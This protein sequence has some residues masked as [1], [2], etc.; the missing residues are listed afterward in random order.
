[1]LLCTEDGPSSTATGHEIV[2]FLRQQS[3][4]DLVTLTDKFYAVVDGHVLPDVP[5]DVYASVDRSNVDL[6]VGVNS[7]EGYMIFTAISSKFG[8]KSEQLDLAT[9]RAFINGFAT[10]FFSFAN[11]GAVG[12]GD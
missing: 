3:P 8:I 7:D 9:A 2:E 4:D 1:M 10:G 12:E 6:M 11:A 5:V